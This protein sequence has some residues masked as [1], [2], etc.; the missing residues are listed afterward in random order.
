HRVPQ[1]RD[2]QRRRDDAAAMVIET[3]LLRWIVLLPALGFLFHVSLGQRARGAVALVGPGAALGAFLVTIAAAMRLHG[4]G[5]DGPLSDPH[6]TWLE[7]GGFRVEAVLPFDALSMVMT[8][9]VCGIGFLIHVYSVGY[10]HDDPGLARFFAYLNLF[11]TAML[12]L[13]LG[14]SL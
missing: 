13:V 1:P 2:H 5:E 11:L 14:A 3:T 9:V 8:L 12:V 6:Y 7:A 10:M 4:L